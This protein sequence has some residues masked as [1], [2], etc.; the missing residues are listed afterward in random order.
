MSQNIIYLIF[1]LISSIFIIDSMLT[2]IKMKKIVNIY[3]KTLIDNVVLKDTIEKESAQSVH[4][5][6]DTEAMIKFLS[7]SRT[8][9]FEYIEEV[10]ATL[11]N[12][13]SKVKPHT[14]HFK[15]FGG[16]FST[17]HNKALETVSSEIVYIEALLPNEDF[18]IKENN[19]E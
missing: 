15:N 3:L 9:A 17:V 11:R 1:M 14:E 2:R 16:T 19:K 6:E 10:Q 18:N 8:A 13:L 5:T 12:F 4:P 7:D